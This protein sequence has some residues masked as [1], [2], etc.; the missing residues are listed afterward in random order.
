MIALDQAYVT[1]YDSEHFLTPP[2]QVLL[3]T[4]LRDIGLHMQILRGI[5]DSRGL[6]YWQ[7]TPEVHLCMHVPEQCR[8]LNALHVQCYGE[9]SMVHRWSLMWSSCAHGP[10]QRTVQ[11]NVLSKYLVQFAIRRDT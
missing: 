10:Y 2:Q 11:K 7:I 5:A 1:I 3:E 6:L 8:L 9:K 4:A